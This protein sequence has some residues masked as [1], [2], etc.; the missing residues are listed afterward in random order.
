MKNF[1]LLLVLPTIMVINSCNMGKEKADMV[2]VNGKIYT[3]DSAGSCVESMAIRDGRIIG[4][5]TKSEMLGK[6][7]AK[8]VFDLQKKVVFPGFIDAHCHFYGY[9]IGLQ[10][11]ELLGSK[12]F[13]EV[14]NRIGK[15]SAQGRRWLVGRGWDQNLLADKH[16]PDNTLLNKLYPSMPV[17]LIRVDG[18]VVLA[19]Q[20]A[21]DLAGI[22]LSNS[23]GTG[24]VEVRNGKLTGILSETAADKI[25]SVVPE[26]S[27]EELKTL[28]QTAERNCVSVGLT[29]VTDA[30]LDY[31]QLMQIDSLQKSGDLSMFVYAM[32]TPDKTNINNLVKKGIYR[33]ERLTVRSIKVYAD[34]SL[35]SRTAKLKKPY[36][37]APGQSGIIVTSPD[38]I[39]TL[40]KLAMDHGY[41]VNTHCIGDSAVRLV[42]D[43]YG[44][45]L[46]GKN[47]LRWRVEHSQVVDPTDVHL[48]G[49]YTI[50]PSV[51]ATH[52]T[53]D[54]RWATDRLGAERVKGAYAYK[55]L[56]EQNGWIPN[57][58]DFPIE[59]ISPLYTFYAAVSRQDF[60]GFPEGGFQ[61]ENALTREEALRSITIWA[62]KANFMESSKGSLEVGKD[63]DF[64]ILDKD[65]MTIPLSE[66]PNLKSQMTFICGKQV[67]GKK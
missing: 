38:S 50:I 35:G 49:D 14:I 42:L 8:V 18:H 16:F 6:Y 67:P 61:K 32:L 28:L 23:Y 11:V 63:A 64:V 39:K 51:Q 41:Q 60:S 65:I 17:M 27:G 46:K 3:V 34:G 21:L 57:G 1:L 33:T 30:G 22:G 4:T 7:R 29:T 2:L 9:A 5:G 20:A 58:T 59:N 13:E 43:I 55:S 15:V 45:L 44:A 53:S 52:A 24:Q 26:P 62:A 12:S 10:Y 54:M 25:R 37:D 31:R 48:F 66:V 47:D 40:C 56:M 36:A 19:N